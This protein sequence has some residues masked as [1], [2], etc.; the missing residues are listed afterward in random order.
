MA[1][2]EKAPAEIVI[3]PCARAFFVYYV[4]IAIF[5]LGPR[6]NPEVQI[7]GLF[8]FSVALGTILGLLVIAA[9]IYLKFGREYR[10]TPKGLITVWRWPSPRQQEIAWVNLGDVLLRRGLIQTI[11]HVGNLMIQD[12]SGGPQ[13]FWYGLPNPKEIQA[14]IERRRP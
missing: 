11:L 2:A 12:K 4:A 7:F 9:V 3:K 13:M 8:N 10:I 5:L 6:F 1:A 14:E